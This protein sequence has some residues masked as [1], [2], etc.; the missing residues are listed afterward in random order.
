MLN[1]Y[2]I[3]SVFF[4]LFQPISRVHVYF[5]VTKDQKSI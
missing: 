4:S 1:G 2:I 3:I 5:Q